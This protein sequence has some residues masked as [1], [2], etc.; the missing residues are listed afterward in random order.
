ML[1]SL[2]LASVCFGGESG[3]NL[4]NKFSPFWVFPLL[5]EKV[6]Q[7]NKFSLRYTQPG[8]EWM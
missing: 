5:A 6:K 3:K 4:L 7:W 1:G 2:S 8:G